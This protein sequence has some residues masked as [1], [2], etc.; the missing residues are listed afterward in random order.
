[1]KVIMKRSI[2]TALCFLFASIAFAGETPGEAFV[3]YPPSSNPAQFLRIGTKIYFTAATAAHGT[4][5]WVTDG[6]ADGTRQVKDVT[7]GAVSTPMSLAEFNGQLYFCTYDGQLWKSDGTAAGT[8]LVK[9][10]GVRS[11]QPIS[12]GSLLYLVAQSGYGDIGQVWVSDGTAD[13]TLR[14]RSFRGPIERGFGHDGKLY[15]TTT[16]DAL[17]GR[18]IWVSD[19]TWFGTRALAPGVVCP[20]SSSGC[21]YNPTFF[22]IGTKVFFTV[23][24]DLW[25]TDGTDGGTTLVKDQAGEYVASTSSFAYLGSTQDIGRTD[26]TTAGT[27]SLKATLPARY[28]VT[29]TVAGSTLFARV[30]YDYDEHELWKSDGTAAGTGLISSY[31]GATLTATDTHAFFSE[32]SYSGSALTHS[33]WATNGGAPAAIKSFSAAA[34]NMFSA[35]SYL[36]FSGATTTEGRELWRS[37][38]TANGTYLLKNIAGENLAGAIAGIV[39]DAT[40]NAPVANAAV[41]IYDKDRRALTFVQSGADGAYRIDNLTFDE[42]YLVAVSASYVRQVY[43]RV[44]CS[45]CSVSNGQRVSVTGPTTTSGIDFPLAPGARF[46]GTVRSPEGDPIKAARVRVLRHTNDDTYEYASAY[47]DQN[48]AYTTSSIEPG[49]Y[50]LMAYDPNGVYAAVVHGVA[51]PCPAYYNCPT[52]SGTPVTGSAGTVTPVA[53]VLP[54]MPHVRGRVVEQDSGLPISGA[55]V[56]LHDA[57]TGKGVATTYSDGNGD[58]ALEGLTTGSY[59]V[60]ARVHPA[61]GYGPSD[62]LAEVWHEQTC[63]TNCDVLAG[64]IL[65]IS[66]GAGAEDVDFTLQPSSAHVRGVVT[67][68]QGGAPVPNLWIR[69][70]SANGY[71]RYADYTDA[72]GAYSMPIEPGTYYL[73][74][75]EQLHGSQCTDCPVTSGTP[76]VVGTGNPTLVVDVAYRSGSAQRYKIRGRVTDQTTGLPIADAAVGWVRGSFSSVAVVTDSDGRYVIEEPSQSA[77]LRVS[78]AGYRGEAYNDAAWPECSYYCYDVPGAELF[79]PA[80]IGADRAGA[81]FAL[82]RNG[83]LTGHVRDADGQGLSGTVTVVNADGAIVTQVQTRTGGSWTASP[84]GPG[85]FK[86]HAGPYMYDWSYTYGQQLYNSIACNGACDTTLGTPITL[87]AGGS[88]TGID[89]TLPRLKGAMKGRV[90]DDVT[91]LGVANAT[92]H[93]RL[94]GASSEQE[95]AY[96]DAGGYYRIEGLRS[97][98]YVVKAYRL[99]SEYYGRMYQGGIC[100]DGSACDNVYGTAVDVTAGAVTSND[101][102]RL[103]K[104]RITAITPAV[105]PVFG[106]TRVT[107]TGTYFPSPITVNFDGFQAQVVSSSATEI[108]VI[109]PPG[110][111]GHAHIELAGTSN[112]LSASNAFLYTTSAAA[113]D[114]NGDFRTDIFWRSTTGL[115]DAWLMDG[116]YTPITRTFATLSDIAWEVQTLG[117]FDGDGLADVFWRNA[118]TGQNV[119]WLMRSGTPLYYYVA[120]QTNGWRVIGA[121]DFDLDGK[122]DLFW[123]NDSTGG[124]QVWFSNGSS[125]RIASS[126]TVSASWRPQG[127]GDVNGDGRDDVLWRNTATG[128]NSAWLM[129]GAAVTARLL[130]TLGG[131]AWNMVAVGD[132]DGDGLDDVLWRNDSTGEHAMWLMNPA[133]VTWRFLMRLDGNW[134]PVGMGDFTGDGRSD[135]FWRHATTGQ[136]SVWVMSGG[137]LTGTIGFGTRS[138]NWKPYLAH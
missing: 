55:T 78:K 63:L 83:T 107:L 114:I 12:A 33:L 5:L 73:K 92:V 101:D 49:D 121:G 113:G 59:V 123:R 54:R 23:V 15:F 16:D 68:E 13:R 44:N 39:R 57:V 46:G 120:S 22:R 86:V 37:D 30:D 95:S 108:A 124:T 75:G 25:V 93:V 20:A 35:G 2:V 45:A 88:I 28:P 71:Q 9:E 135:I 131:S 50:R 103:A 74:A 32:S 112:K 109:T 60:Q 127:I 61:Y 11:L 10:M 8:V 105:G 115:N 117:D 52:A 136:L 41:W 53:F 79:D 67:Y 137:T 116:R 38:G 6:T 111:L 96:T 133:S 134:K 89:F 99:E 110:A 70:Y 97:G 7:P 94:L 91:G 87:T 138:T 4:E 98:S 104:M 102:M 77:Y 132:T 51:E 21:Y 47:T 19:G 40:T 80:T 84:P 58:Y 64:R 69:L 18:Q 128:Q 27:F 14:L 90:V 34:L 17:L 118:N 85:P 122:D 26:G 66:I 48:G 72:L 56:V 42:Y 100:F 130:P 106:G 24:S 62:Y 1:M 125:F 119:L 43:P 36:L 126:L 129:N 81:D 82:F 65:E 76:I 3:P 29:G 31:S